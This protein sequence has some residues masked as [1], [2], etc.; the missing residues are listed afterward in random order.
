MKIPYAAIF[1][2]LAFVLS[3]S[4]CAGNVP[5]VVKK[6]K[7][8]E[9]LE[10]YT[11]KSKAIAAGKLES[12]PVAS[13]FV[14]LPQ[15]YASSPKRRYPVVYGLHG[16][17]DGALSIL[18]NLRGALNLANP[19]APEVIVVSV[20]G[21]NSLGGSFFANSPA[22]G[23]WEDLVTV[24]TVALV[25]ARYRTIAA[26]EGRMIAGFSMGGGGAWNIAIAHPEVFS[27]AWVCCPGAWDQNGLRDTLS[28]WGSMYRTAYGAAFSPDFTL[29]SPYATF[30]KF[31][32]TYADSLLIAKWERGFGG[33]DDKLAAY[34]K[35]TAKLKAIS[36]V[37]GTRDG[38]GWIPRGTQYIA[39]KMRLAGLPVEIRA[40]NS[41]HAVTDEM[42]AESFLPLVR[43][44]FGSAGA[45]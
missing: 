15:S 38:Y 29:P 42:L 19:S 45:K 11:I 33:I 2:S 13:V 12:R 26:P 6:S 39:G 3:V 34:G 40:F 27:S 30:P 17:G 9:T 31:D 35:M 8:S 41:G 20:E 25:D 43:S 16:F 23:N 28:G 10:V 22:T 32:G 44:V 4:S 7:R 5:E 14:S 24:E 21:G 36:F 37:Y 1:A 18:N